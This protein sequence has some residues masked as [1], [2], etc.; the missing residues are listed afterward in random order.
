MYDILFLAIIAV[1][2]WIGYNDGFL[3]AVVGFAGVL[4]ASVGGFLLYPYLTEILEKTPLYTTIYT[5]I[6][7]TIT[8]NIQEGSLPELFIKYS[9]ETLA[10]VIESMSAGVTIIILNIISIV[11][12]ILVIKLA[13]YFLKRSAKWI[14]DLPVIGIINRILGMIVTGVSAIIFIF[15]FVAIIVTPPSNQIEFSQEIC[16]GINE[17]YLLSR[18]M[19]YNFFVSFK[20]LSNI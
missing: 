12:I 20:S 16:R 19:D 15:I 13:F 7:K 8:P 4:A 3:K 17:S 2:L 9:T 10:G 18:V 11:A 14:N 5:Q 1:A 6:E